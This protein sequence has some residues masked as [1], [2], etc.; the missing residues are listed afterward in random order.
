MRALRLRR[1]TVLGEGH[2]R[3]LLEDVDDA[4]EK[5]RIIL[6]DESLR[7]RLVEQGYEWAG[8]FSWERNSREILDYLQEIIDAS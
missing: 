5:I 3:R 1:V 6:T 7:N 8:S 4:A 2:A